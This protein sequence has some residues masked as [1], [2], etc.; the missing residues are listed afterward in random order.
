MVKGNEE[1]YILTSKAKD[2]LNCKFTWDKVKQQWKLLIGDTNFINY[3]EESTKQLIQTI[4]GEK[5]PVE[6]FISRGEL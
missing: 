4:T 2:I 6:Y 5:N 3:I 1:S